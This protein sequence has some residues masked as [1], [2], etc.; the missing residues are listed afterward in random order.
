MR[1]KDEKLVAIRRDSFIL[2][3][4][5]SHLRSNCKAIVFRQPLAVRAAALMAGGTPALPV[6]TS[7]CIET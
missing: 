1:M 7:I 4:R 6:I 2:R 5:R 3:L